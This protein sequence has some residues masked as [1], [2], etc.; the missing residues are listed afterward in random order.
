[1]PEHLPGDPCAARSLRPP[2]SEPQARP[3]RPRPSHHPD[4]ACARAAVSNANVD[5]APVSLASFASAARRFASTVSGVPIRSGAFSGGSNG[6]LFITSS[7]SNNAVAIV[8]PL[9]WPATSR[10]SITRA[11]GDRLRA[12]APR[13]PAPICKH[14]QLLFCE[15][16]CARQLF[17]VTHRLIFLST[18]ESL[19]RNE[20]LM[21]LRNG[22]FWSGS[23]WPDPDGG[24]WKGGNPN[25]CEPVPR[26]PACS[27]RRQGRR[28]AR[29]A[30][31]RRP[32]SGFRL[33]GRHG[34]PVPTGQSGWNIRSYVFTYIAMT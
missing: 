8:G 30:P 11:R 18:T 16:I 33:A 5:P 23:K 26:L 2:P 15:R 31:R 7:I 27:A 13:K 3:P 28:N 6:R 20:S 22:H 29:S 10:R 19:L 34:T 32:G 4:A 12:S 21:L 14:R 25:A 9:N 1:M 17:Q 24:P